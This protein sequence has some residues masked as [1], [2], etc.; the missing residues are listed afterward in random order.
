MSAKLWQR[1]VSVAAVAAVTMVGSA[2]AQVPG[3]DRSKC[4]TT[5]ATA[6]PAGDPENRGRARIETGGPAFVPPAR[7]MP[8][9]VEVQGPGGETQA[10]PPV[11]EPPT[12]GASSSPPS[13]QPPPAVPGLPPPPTSKKDKKE[14]EDDGRPRVEAI[15]AKGEVPDERLLDIGIGVFDAALDE[16]DEEKLAAKGL[17]TELRKAEGRFVAF[18]LKKTME[19]TGNWGAVRVLPGPGEGLDVFVSGRIVRSDGKRLVLEVQAADATGRRWFRRRYTGEADLRAY[20]P[21]RVGR[22]DPFQE[23]YNRIANDL[24]GERDD[25]HPDQLVAVRRVASLRFGAELAPRAFSPFL[26]SNGS[27]RYAL[28]RLPADGDPMVRRVAEIRDRDQMFVD[29][30]NDY[31]LS[32]YERMGGPY[33]NWRQYSYE[34]QAALDK[35]NRAST[36]KKILGAAAMLGGIMMSGSDSQGG[37]AAGD[38]AL[39]GGYAV[40]QAGM[41]QAQQKALHEAALKELAVSVDGDVAPLLVE[42]EG[43]QLR[44]TGSAEKQFTEWRELL[45]RVFTVETGVPGDPNAPAAAPAPPAAGTPPA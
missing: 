6:A 25:L 42:V 9:V 11:P 2:W 4:G 5:G 34:E 23:V 12:A 22:Q 35:I 10:S 7:L 3:P 14:K 24:L 37:R 19:G 40:L 17:S 1:T 45:H 8:A 21:D 28:L 33:S 18:H 38:I 20:R 39:L 36:L 13:P 43:H 27:G 44:L 41:Q 31:Y 15:Q 29:T 30:L 32:F 16:D 26:K